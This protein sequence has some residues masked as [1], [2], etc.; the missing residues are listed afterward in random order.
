LCGF[1]FRS[2]V[3]AGEQYGTVLAVE[4]MQDP[5]FHGLFQQAQAELKVAGF[6]R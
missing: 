2:D 5:I 1:H 6:A 3:T 4:M